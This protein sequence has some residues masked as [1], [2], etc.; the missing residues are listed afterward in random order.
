MKLSDI[1]IIIPSSLDFLKPYIEA[2]LK[3]LE[4]RSDVLICLQSL[5]ARSES[6][7]DIPAEACVLRLPVVIGTGMTG[8][9][10]HLVQSIWR[11]TFFHFPDNEMRLSVVHA[12]DVARAVALLCTTPRTGAVYTLTDGVDPTLHDLAEA[13]AYRMCNKRI[14]NLS[15]KPQQWLG[16]VLYG[17]RHYTEYTVS[18]CYDGSAFL[19]DYPDFHPTDV[20]TY[21]RT[22]VYDDTSL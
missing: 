8:F 17:R 1:N 11:G 21:L 4:G 14:S 10:R 3:P 9:G 20:C 22:H 15:T 6:P 5:D 19:T 18:R 7:G 12:V 2:A 16:R 13:L